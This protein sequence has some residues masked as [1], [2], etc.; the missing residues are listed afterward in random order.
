MLSNFPETIQTF[1]HE[2]KTMTGKTLLERK[3]N[4]VDGCFCACAINFIIFNLFA[5]HNFVHLEH[6]IGLI[7]S[8]SNIVSVV[9]WTLNGKIA[10]STERLSLRSTINEYI[11]TNICWY[12]GMDRMR[13]RLMNKNIFVLGEFDKNKNEWKQWWL[14]CLS[15]KG[16]NIEPTWHFTIHEL[17][18]PFDLQLDYYYYF[19]GV[20]CSMISQHIVQITQPNQIFENF[21]LT[22]KRNKHL[23]G[24]NIIIKHCCLIWN[25]FTIHKSAICINW[26]SIPLL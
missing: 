8:R 25:S 1:I 19:D 9:A 26:A 3:I 14:V 10:L 16:K 7:I 13:W 4:R 21:R 6:K 5:G 24:W 12:F 17:I 18:Q 23:M 11:F 20:N 22:D 15:G 2:W